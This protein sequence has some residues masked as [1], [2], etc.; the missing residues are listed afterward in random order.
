VDFGYYILNTYIPELDGTG[1]DL[2]GRYREQI[3]AAEAAGFDTVWATEHHFRTFGGMTPNPQMLLA[4]IGQWAPKLRLGSSV[5]ILPLR[6]PLQVAEDF[7]VLDVLTDGRLE[8]GAGRGMVLSGFAGFGVDWDTAQDRM[9]E[10]LTLIDRL[11]TEPRV[12]FAG[13]FFQCENVALMPR[14]VQQPRP[15]IWVTANTDPESFRWIGARGYDLMTLP[16]LFPPDRTRELVGVYREAR[17]AAGHTAP[18]RIM[19]MYPAHVAETA[20][21]ARERCEAAWNRWRDFIVEEVRADPLRHQEAD[22]RSAMLSYDNMVSE[23]R[24][25]F[26]SVEDCVATVRWLAETFGLTHLG[27]T[28]HF[29]GLSQ[30]AGLRTVDLWGRAVAPAVNGALGAGA[31]R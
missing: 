10:A 16:W 15:P 22:R 25:I 12:S 2:Y 17:L 13:Q 18:P 28:F 5:S 31:G 26:G 4:V 8:F 20:A 23:R 11:W 3:Q 21:L 29:G 27:L 30:D 19:A 14:P 9:K 7:A 6:N 1:S 24:A